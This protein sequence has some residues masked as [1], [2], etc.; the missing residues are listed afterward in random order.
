MEEK[1]DDEKRSPKILSASGTRVSNDKAHVSWDFTLLSIRL[2][3]VIIADDRNWAS[4]C[5]SVHENDNPIV[6][7]PQFGLLWRTITTREHSTGSIQRLPRIGR[8][9]TW[10]RVRANLHKSRPLLCCEI[11][12]PSHLC[13]FSETRRIP[14]E[15]PRLHVP[16]IFFD[17]AG[18]STRKVTEDRK[19]MKMMVPMMLACQRAHHGISQN[20]IHLRPPNLFVCIWR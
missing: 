4:R 11:V 14:E 19:P 5:R 7:V 13:E 18:H 6:H 15:G 9:R 2:V 8:P 1:L 12:V 10:T 3:T 16:P 20:L 17:V